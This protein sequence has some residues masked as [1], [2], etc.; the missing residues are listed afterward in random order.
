MLEQRYQ[1]HVAGEGG[2]YETLTLD[3]PI[4]KVRHQAMRQQWLYASFSS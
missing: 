3:C 2:E 4:F 1:F